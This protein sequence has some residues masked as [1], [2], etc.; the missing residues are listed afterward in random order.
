MAF[1][2]K[3]ELNKHLEED[4]NRQ[5]E[6]DYITFAGMEQRHVKLI[7]N[8]LN[9]DFDKRDYHRVAKIKDVQVIFGL[10][11]N[12]VLVVRGSLGC[13]FKPPYGANLYILSAKIKNTSFD[14]IQGVDLDIYHDEYRPE[15]IPVTED[16]L[17]SLVANSDFV[18]NM[19]QFE[20]FMET[21]SYYKEISNA[22]NNAES[23]DI[24]EISDEYHFLPISEAGDVT[25][26]FESVYSN[27]DVIIGYVVDDFKCNS[28]PNEIQR[29]IQTVFDVLIAYKDE[30]DKK[31]KIKSIKR[32]SEN[33]YLHYSPVI[34]ENDFRSL[35]NFELIN[36][37]DK[38][39][40]YIVLT[41]KAKNYSG[42]RYLNLY[43]VGQKIKL[44][45]IENS[46]RLINEGASGAA[47]ELLEYLVGSEKMMPNEGIIRDNIEPYIKGLNESQKAAFC[48]AIDGSPIS[49]IKGPP[50]TGKTHVINAIAQY[51]VKEL[52]EKVIISSQTHVAID[53][54]LDKL[55]SN[56]DL[57][58]PNRITNRVNKYDSDNIDSTLYKTWGAEFESHNSRAEAKSLAKKMSEYEK[59]FNG[60]KRFSYSTTN[61]MSDYS[62]I[63]A[64]TTT[65]VIAGRKGL[66]VLKGYDWLIIDEVSKCPVTEV[67]RYL[68]YVKHIILVGDDYQLPPLLEINKE[69]IENLPTFDEDKFARLKSEYE[70]SVFS[71]VIKKANESHRLAI[72]NVNYRATPDILKTY[73][74]FYD[75]Q[76]E[77]GRK[78]PSKIIMKPD[79][80]YRNKDVYFFDVKNGK[81]AFDGPS[82]FNTEEL[83]AIKLCLND[84]MQE[85]ENAKEITVSAI[86]PYAAQIS[87]FTKENKNLI[88]EMKKTFRS[89]ECDT[90]DSFQGRE[91]DIVLLSTVVTDNSLSNFLK[92]FRRINVSMSRAKDKLIIFG[93]PI[94]LSRIEMTTSKGENGRTYFAD[95]IGGIKENAGMIV[96]DRGVKYYGYENSTTIR[97]K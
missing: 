69:D 56:Y 86:F 30:K 11:D 81:E 32:F 84:L 66:E 62:V 57:I 35:S 90:V 68:P 49:L 47:S 52:N 40:K 73:N 26:D 71:S 41:G 22:V 27:E 75:N 70:S 91:T 38:D 50:G 18:Y 89:F 24:E 20:D 17:D 54:V 42:A 2:L 15:P 55:M 34:Q 96:F 61:K 64:T 33:L 36:I 74:V 13:S 9:F 65:P 76:L 31:K 43:D 92:D 67:L 82:R 87:K 12:Q 97:F 25:D 10:E 58:I 8:K 94:T 23:F 78:T 4:E 6:R 60:A 95:I 59:K 1:H 19:D 5:K 29:E 46:L 85:V 7:T 93:N 21:F 51:I 28:L 72:L 37:R 83:E 77:L 88:N 53:N 63:G 39:A 3:F 48:M 80:I 16:L 79:S 44:D 45:S 14:S